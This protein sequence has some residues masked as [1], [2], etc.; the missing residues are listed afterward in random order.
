MRILAEFCGPKL[1]YHITASF[2]LLKYIDIILLA[3]LDAMRFISDK[4]PS[5]MR[6]ATLALSFMGSI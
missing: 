4:P 1:G 2:K 6:E 5:E 3:A